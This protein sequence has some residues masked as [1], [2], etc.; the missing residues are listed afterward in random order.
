MSLRPASLTACAIVLFLITQFH[1]PPN[2]FAQ[3]S[4]FSEFS[5]IYIGIPTGGVSPNDSATAID[6]IDQGGSILGGTS[7]TLTTAPFVTKYPYLKRIDNDGNIVWAKTYRWPT[8]LPG[9][10][11]VI[12]GVATSTSGGQLDGFVATGYV[13][14]PT[15]AP[16]ASPRRLFVMKV[17]PNGMFQWAREYYST[18]P[19]GAPVGPGAEN[20]GEDI[21]QDSKGNYVVVG[22]SGKTVGFAQCDMPYPIGSPPP[23]PATRRVRDLVVLS[24]NHGGAPLWDAVYSDI[25]VNPIAASGGAF[26]TLWGLAITEIPSGQG[27]TVSFAIVGER[28]EPGK[29]GYASEIG[30]LN[31]SSNPSDLFAMSVSSTLN[32]FPI[33]NWAKYYR[34]PAYNNFRQI[35]H[36]RLL[37]VTTT[38]DNYIAATGL[39]RHSLSTPP[40]SL[41][42]GSVVLKMDLNGSIAPIDPINFPNPTTWASYVNSS[43]AD[44]LTGIA[45]LAVP[46][47]ADYRLAT[48][49]FSN[50][51]KTPV[52]LPGSGGDYDYYSLLLSEG[53]NWIISS[54]LGSQYVRDAATGIAARANGRGVS[55]G[56]VYS[57]L[58]YRFM[59]RTEDASICATCPENLTTQ[60]LKR[61]IVDVPIQLQSVHMLSTVPVY[62]PENPVVFSEFLCPDCSEASSAHQFQMHY[63]ASV[64]PGPPM[65]QPTTDN[66]RCPTPDNYIPFPGN[67]GVGEKAM[68]GMENNAGGLGVAGW[69]F[70]PSPN[71]PMPKIYVLNLDPDGL[72]PSSDP[73][74]WTRQYGLSVMGLNSFGQKN[75]DEP[76]LAFAMDENGAAANFSGYVVGGDL[77]PGMTPVGGGDV[78]AYKS[79]YADAFLM[80]LDKFGGGSWARRYGSTAYH[81]Y[82]FARD[83]ARIRNSSG[84]NTGI[85]LC[86]Y[87]NPPESGTLLPTDDDIFDVRTDM[88]GLIG[89][90]EWQHSVGTSYSERA[91]SVAPSTNE[92]HYLAGYIDG[93]A[94][95]TLDGLLVGINQFGT[96]RSVG[97]SSAKQFLRYSMSGNQQFYDVT[98]GNAID[99]RVFAVGSTDGGA[100]QGSDILF[101]ALLPDDASATPA[102]VF[103]SY[104]IGARDSAT[105]VRQTSD[106]GFIIT[107]TTDIPN[108]AIPGIDGPSDMGIQTFV[109]KLSCDYV[110]QWCRVMPGWVQTSCS[111]RAPAVPNLIEEDLK[112][113][114]DRGEAVIQT[115]DGGYFVAGYTQT[116]DFHHQHVKSDMYIVRTNCDGGVCASAEIPVVR[117]ALSA[118]RISHTPLIEDY[119]DVEELTIREYAGG[120]GCTICRGG[121]ALPKGV[122]HLHLQP[123]HA[124]APEAAIAVQAYP[125]P[126]HQGQPLLFE[127]SEIL[128]VCSYRV[129]DNSGGEVIPL[130]KTEGGH[131][132]VATD[133]LNPGTYLV[134]FEC[135]GGKRYVVKVVVA[136]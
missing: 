62:I 14:Y 53:G 3:S 89:I 65:D 38:H 12:L 80:S 123:E 64:T 50:S 113:L 109:L 10:T 1:S 29:Y 15:N 2:V 57:A 125:V 110:P 78:H 108:D 91:Y 103:Y 32:G 82:E 40:F 130:T 76:S 20:V 67:Q 117:T 116:Y 135:T 120:V 63:S 31:C 41:D 74:Y 48:V 96:V 61:L 85:A 87:L 112:Y 18:T 9:D 59:S 22:Y 27:S 51:Y 84:T 16:G 70:I 24:I 129:F 72:L 42:T 39:V 68:D 99:D 60:V 30:P 79:D 127:P 52:P 4:T 17:D 73:T 23:P 133:R 26:W 128:A 33:V 13:V 37:S 93:G 7:L 114:A 134:Q 119:G 95:G 47:T 83:I 98:E 66:G 8:L 104:H 55:V 118:T 49:G 131:V 45:E 102:E 6:V 107:G 81:Y 46:G 69:N 136:E 115:D 28:V 77:R 105:A 21:I 90:N 35:T 75:A 106:N 25:A 86:G 5:R 36:G 58:S 54:I 126:V 19:T 92:G 34:L 121:A 44:V 43:D 132:S 71:C 11:G 101:A 100:G 111:T 122:D 88:S 97:S 56:S 124:A 94:Q